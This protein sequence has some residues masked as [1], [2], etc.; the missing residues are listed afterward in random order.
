MRHRKATGQGVKMDSGKDNFPTFGFYKIQFNPASFFATTKFKLFLAMHFYSHCTPLAVF[1]SLAFI[2][3]LAAQND[4][5]VIGDAVLTP[6]EIASGASI[7]YFIRF[8]NISPDTTDQVVI[9]DTLD[10]R[11]DPTSFT[12]MASSHEYE[13]LRDGDG[14]VVRWYFNDIA[15]PDSA[16]DKPGSLGFIIFTVQPKPF[17]A[18]GQVIANHACISFAEG[19]VICTNDAFVWIDDGAKADEPVSIRDIRVVPNPN[20]GEFE[21]R[22]IDGAQH[23]GVPATDAEWW[24]TDIHGKTVWDGSVADASSAGNAVM[25]EKPSPGLYLLW[26][27][28]SGHL[29]VEQFTVIR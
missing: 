29:Q 2:F 24:I 19:P 7:T 16:S 4:K 15:L 13:L 11:L 6:D 8:Q 25:M 20:F 10:P 14:E 22:H 9:R 21:V 5:Q 18:P 1:I 23:S 27:K 28:E 3:P 12:M 17:L 26:V